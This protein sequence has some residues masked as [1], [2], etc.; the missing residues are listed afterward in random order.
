MKYNAY[1]R[2]PSSEGEAKLN[3]TLELL[4]RLTL[5]IAHKRLSF[6]SPTTTHQLS[7]RGIGYR[8]QLTGG[9]SDTESPNSHSRETLTSTSMVE[10]VEICEALVTLC[11]Q[12]TFGYRF[13]AFAT[14]ESC[15][16]DKSLKMSPRTESSA[17]NNSY[18]DSTSL[19]FAFNAMDF[20]TC[21]NCNTP[22]SLS[23]MA[24]VNICD[25]SMA[26]IAGDNQPL[27]EITSTMA[28]SKRKA[29]GKMDS[30]SLARSPGN[31]TR[32]K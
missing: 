32:L 21:G 11:S 18:T 7:S 8:L 22:A 16:L 3:L 10:L 23:H 29:V 27:L 26:H 17:S 30:K 5:L 14:S 19:S 2:L 15:R 31:A 6:S 9:K 1:L 12:S 20:V 25:N 28:K 4:T 13:A 24:C